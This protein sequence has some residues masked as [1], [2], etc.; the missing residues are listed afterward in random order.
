[1]ESAWAPTV[2]NAWKKYEQVKS[3]TKYNFETFGTKYKIGTSSLTFFQNP[4]N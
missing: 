3:N 4:R 2:Q 1:M